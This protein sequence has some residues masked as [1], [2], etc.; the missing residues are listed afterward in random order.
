MTDLLER[1][2][3]LNEVSEFS[4]CNAQTDIAEA[5]DEPERWRHRKQATGILAH[6]RVPLYRSSYALIITTIAT[7]LCGAG[8]WAIATRIYPAA[9]VGRVSAAVSMMIL[10]SGVAQF[11]LIATLP[12]LLPHAGAGT[13]RLVVMSYLASAAMAIV[14][15]G[16]FSAAAVH[17]HWMGGFLNG[18]WYLAPWFVMAVTAWCVFTLQDSVLTGLREAVWV[19]IENAGFSIAKIALLVAFSGMAAHVGLF[20]SWTIPM[21]VTLVP[22]NALIMRKLIPR[23]VRRTSTTATGLSKLPLRKMIAADYFGGLCQLAS[24]SLLP[25][26]VAAHLGL[27]ISGRFYAIWAVTIALDLLMSS[28]ATSLTVEGS[29]DELELHTHLARTLKLG[30]AVLIPTAIAAGALAPLAVSVLAHS[31][32]PSLTMLLRLVAAATVFRF[33]NIVALAVA[34]VRK[35][36]RLV[37]AVQVASCALILGG[38]LGLITSR[39]LVAVG[40]A[41]FGAQLLVAARTIPLVAST[42]RRT[43]PKTRRALPEVTTRQT[44]RRSDVI[45]PVS[46]SVAGTTMWAAGVAL[47]SE[48]DVGGLGL[49]N[50]LHPLF[51]IGIITLGAGF[52]YAITRPVLRPVVL[53]PQLLVMLFMLHGSVGL[54]EAEPRFFSAYLHIGFIERITRAG[55]TL[56]N[57]DARYSWPGSFSLAAM[58]TQIAGLDSAKYFIRYAPVFFNAMYLAPLWVIVRSVTKSTRA[59]W[60]MVWMFMLGNWVGQD[61]ISPQA[62]NYGLA[63]TF[64]AILL[65]FYTAPPQDHPDARKPDAIRRGRHLTPRSQLFGY[66]RVELDKVE[67]AITAGWQ[68][69]SLLGMQLLIFS[70]IC[71]SHQL[72]PLFVMGI[73]TLLVITRRCTLRSLPIMQVVIYLGWISLG[74]DAFWKGHLQTVLSSFGSVGQNVN[75]GVAGRLTGGDQRQLV[76]YSRMGFAAV[77][78]G[79]AAIGLFRR[80]RIGVRQKGLIVATLAAIPVVGLQSYGGEVVLRAYLFT[81]PLLVVFGALAVFPVPGRLRRPAVATAI[82]AVFTAAI[83]P[84]FIV[85]RYG[86]EEFERVDPQEAEAI[87]YVYANAPLGANL[88]AVSRNLPWRYQALE[89]YHYFPSDDSVLTDRSTIIDFLNKNSSTAYFV[90]TT[91]QEQFGIQL[92]GLKPGWVGELAKT[93]ESTGRFR[94]VFSSPNAKAYVYE[95]NYEADV[96]NSHEVSP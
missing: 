83:V 56:P 8:Y 67:P 29:H 24:T 33:V 78:V 27:A 14:I 64:I 75:S 41:Y 23:H 95:A 7:S 51:F 91:S 44:E 36:T 88:V 59:R 11:N 72:T 13:K 71:M 53:V 4:I 66:D 69:V 43:A 93:L 86:N 85:A 34:R 50:A 25:V 55:A 70:V 31:S 81:L 73:T 49:L 62:L 82:I 46:L 79:L 76:L 1:T 61:Y 37:I 15:S 74:A 30:G 19:P 39:G 18:S 47:T 58:I 5:N 57:L 21:L 65:R 77:M 87:R 90:L 84:L 42:L 3:P 16:T 89:Q 9:E 68:R 60:L 28:L 52:A 12:R 17:W 6:T 96:V 48:Y 20:A 63:I 54:I 45:I 10:L 80:W 94:V 32:D 35:R 2:T 38:T 92:Y 40:W 26:I 22:V